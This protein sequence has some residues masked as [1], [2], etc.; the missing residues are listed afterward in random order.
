MTLSEHL[1]VALDNS[2][3]LRIEG[4]AY[5]QTIDELREHVLPMWPHG[6]VVEESRDHRWRVQFA[7]RPWTSSGQAALL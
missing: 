7:N 5:Q 1:F 6:V 2:G 3:E 4:I